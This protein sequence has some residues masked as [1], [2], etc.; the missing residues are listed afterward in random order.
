[1]KLK[2]NIPHINAFKKY[3]DR[4]INI[5]REIARINDKLYKHNMK[6]ANFLDNNN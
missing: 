5:E 3:L 6:W 4:Q 2:G 1:M